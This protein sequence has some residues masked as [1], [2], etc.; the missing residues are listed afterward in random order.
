MLLPSRIAEICKGIRLRIR[1]GFVEVNVCR[2]Y[3]K[4][5]K[6][7][8]TCGKSS[9]ETRRAKTPSNMRFTG[10]SVKGTYGPFT[11]DLRAVVAR[12]LDFADSFR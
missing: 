4:R 8:R 3:A 2:A 9:P 11:H 6:T 5:A 1:P 10:R 7:V 12:A